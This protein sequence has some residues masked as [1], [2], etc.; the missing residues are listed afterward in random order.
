MYEEDLSNSNITTDTS[1][2]SGWM[3]IIMESLCI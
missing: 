2:F 1:L 3:E